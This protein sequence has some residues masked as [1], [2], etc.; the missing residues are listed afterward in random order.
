[1]KIPESFK[2]EMEKTFYDKSIDVLKKKYAVD[3]E[4][5]Y[6][7]KKSDKAYNFM[8]NVSFSNFKA[9][10]EEYG[11]EHDISIVI[12]TALRHKNNIDLS[13]LIS[14]KDVIYEIT[15]KIEKDSHLMLVGAVW[16]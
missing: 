9:V 11:I 1:M 10:K 12:T 16:E 5:D 13:T 6:I 2:T 8:G 3:A 4:G 7:V 15:D 14:Y